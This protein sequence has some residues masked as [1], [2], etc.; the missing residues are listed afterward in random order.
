I[1]AVDLP[2]G[3]AKELELFIND[4]ESEAADE[5]EDDEEDEF[6]DVVCVHKDTSV[7]VA[8]LTA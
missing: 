4:D 7:S 3:H 2:S 1:A 5:T 8:D 6:F